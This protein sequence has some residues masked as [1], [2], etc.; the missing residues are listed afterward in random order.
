MSQSGMRDDE[1]KIIIEEQKVIQQRD[2][3][4]GDD[5]YEREREQFSAWD[6]QQKSKIPK[7]QTKWTT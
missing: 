1:K 3:R 2:I 6:E 4:G 5:V 7:K